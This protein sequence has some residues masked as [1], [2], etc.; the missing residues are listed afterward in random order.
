[1]I[2]NIVTI[3]KLVWWTKGECEV[4][5]LRRGHYPTSVMAKLPNDKTT[6]IELAELEVTRG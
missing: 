6:E 1:M 5:V 3:P 2:E 4:E